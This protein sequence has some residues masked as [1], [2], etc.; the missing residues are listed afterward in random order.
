MSTTLGTAL[1]AF[2]SYIKPRKG[3]KTYTNVN[4]ATL[5]K[6]MDPKSGVF[7]ATLEELAD[8]SKE[9]QDSIITA[10]KRTQKPDKNPHADFFC[11]LL[12]YIATIYHINIIVDIPSNLTRTVF[13][14][15]IKI[16]K[17]LQ[18]TPMSA[19]DVGEKVYLTERSADSY[20]TSMSSEKND[21]GLIINGKKV[22]LVF[23]RPAGKYSLEE[24]VHPLVL[25][26]NLMQV[27]L[28]IKGLHA[29]RING[30]EEIT[31]DVALNIWTQLSEAGQDMIIEKAAETGF[32]LE[33]IM[34]ASQ[35]AVVPYRTEHE[36]IERDRSHKKFNIPLYVKQRKPLRI[37]YFDETLGSIS[38]IDCEN[39]DYANG[40]QRIV[41]KESNGKDWCIDAKS[42]LDIQVVIV[43]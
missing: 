18:Y 31:K 8:D 23:D 30:Y 42:I 34:E 40:G 2:I 21:E 7:E 13:E 28:L 5:K 10:L 39:T 17:L 25:T 6:N 4:L 20:L 41:I 33:W 11:D 37:T 32:P 27:I 16:I 29:A 15:Q 19:K 43:K 35:E 14:M 12:H 3:T 9:L 36:Y 38:E 24:T 22:K 1:D 26:P